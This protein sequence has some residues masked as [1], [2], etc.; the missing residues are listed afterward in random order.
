MCVLQQ[1]GQQW[2]DCA[3]SSR[4][5]HRS[6][7]SLEDLKYQAIV[8]LVFILMK[9][10]KIIIALFFTFFLCIAFNVKTVIMCF[11]LNAWR[12]DT[13]RC[14]RG[15]EKKNNNNK[16][17]NVKSPR[18]NQ[19][20]KIVEMIINRCVQSEGRNWERS[21]YVQRSNPAAVLQPASLFFFFFDF[22]ARF[23]GSS[24]SSLTTC[25]NQHHRCQKP[26]RSLE[27]LERQLCWLWWSVQQLPT[28][29]AN[30]KKYINK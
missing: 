24:S 25:C 29:S 2:N 1:F 17:K 4:D 8:S 26:R 7:A 20:R 27:L 10:V 16:T 11:S 23:Q 5:K 6:F 21:D 12:G 19:E 14:T 18:E 28:Q 15:G 13:R 3:T 22:L 30:L 9:N